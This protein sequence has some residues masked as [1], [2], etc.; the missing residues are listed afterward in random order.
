MVTPIRRRSRTRVDAFGALADP[1][2]RAIVE[3]LWFGGEATAG[4]IAAAFPRI[5]RPAVS[6]HLRRLREAR[7]LRA[8]GEGRRR[9]YSLDARG[10]DDLDAWVERYRATW[11]RRFTVLRGAA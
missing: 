10:I 4:A 5:S 2:R 11:Q 1:T 9:L 3:L 6:R 8:R 7:V